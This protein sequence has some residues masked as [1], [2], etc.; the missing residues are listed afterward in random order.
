MHKNKI[1]NTDE[2]PYFVATFL[3]NMQVANALKHGESTHKCNHFGKCHVDARTC[4]MYLMY[5]LKH[6]L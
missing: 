1:Q 2:M 5:L 4:T 6:Y 3:H